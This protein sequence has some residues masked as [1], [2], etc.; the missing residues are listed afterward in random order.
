[1]LE[2]VDKAEIVERLRPA[3]RRH[4]DTFRRCASCGRVYWQGPHH[5]RLLALIREVRA[6]GE[7]ALPG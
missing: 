5:R 6:L 7:R 2:A 4:F 3:T 1:V